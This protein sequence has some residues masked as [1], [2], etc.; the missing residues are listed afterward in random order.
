MS[1]K[2][3]PAYATKMLRKLSEDK[4]YWRA[5]ENE[6]SV[7]VAS[8]DEEPVIPEYDYSEVAKNITEIDE[9]MV[10]IKHA[11][12]LSNTKNEV[13]VGDVA[14][15][16]DTILVRMA[17]LNGRKD[18]LDCMRKRQPKSRVSSGYMAGRKSVPEY[19]YINYDLDVVKKEYERIDAE[20]AEMQIALD[21]YNHTEEIEVDI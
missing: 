6:D 18:V 3:T 1:T 13:Q 19:E 21:R 14:M 2:M 4:E 12:N 20:I 10:K 5:R 17:Q 8:N 11:I 16:I 7:Y 15:T 9:K